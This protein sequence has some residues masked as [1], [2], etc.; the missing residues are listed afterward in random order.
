MVFS[1]KVRCSNIVGHLPGMLYF[2]FFL[3][4]R[5]VGSDNSAR[6]EF[7]YKN[8]LFCLSHYFSFC[9]LFIHLL[10][11]VLGPKA[12]RRNSAAKR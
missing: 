5:V 9:R 12:S 6:F 8:L 1:Q 3:T 7:Q 2:L 11:Y 10:L 4:T